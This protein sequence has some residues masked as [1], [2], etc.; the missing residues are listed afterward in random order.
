MFERKILADS[1]KLLLELI[2]DLI[3]IQK[4]LNIND[5]P[6]LEES[7]LGK[8]NGSLSSSVWNEKENG[9]SSSSVQN[10]KG[11]CSI[12]E[13]KMVLFAFRLTLLRFRYLELENDS[14][15]KTETKINILTECFFSFV[16]STLKIETNV[17]TERFFFFCKFAPGLGIPKSNAFI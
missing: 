7:R 1:Y 17:L 10:R 15:L 5:N 8:E 13:S 9:S 2:R 14:A 12:L 16:D 3:P 4:N 11:K 6:I